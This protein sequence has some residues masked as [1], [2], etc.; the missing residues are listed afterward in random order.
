LKRGTITL[1]CALVVLTAACS[2]SGGGGSALSKEEFL[3]QGNAICDAGNQKL[4]DAANKAFSDSS[5]QPSDDEITKFVNETVIPGVK[6]QIDDLDKLVPPKELQKDVD[7]LLS[8][9]RDAI[10]SA[11]S[12]P[13][14]FVNGDPFADVNKEAVNL[15]LTSCGGGGDGS[16]SDSASS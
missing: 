2:S 1:F 3:K 6:K 12:D 9:A 8:H 16:G 10:K 13:S 11:E 7:T 15:G 14:Q 5:A 4:D